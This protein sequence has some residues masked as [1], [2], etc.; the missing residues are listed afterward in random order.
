MYHSTYI[1]CNMLNAKHQVRMHHHKYD[2]YGDPDDVGD[3][4]NNKLLN[5]C[6]WPQP[7]PW[8]T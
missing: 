2:V 8:V 5:I 3:K 6:K 4:P 1:D 7:K